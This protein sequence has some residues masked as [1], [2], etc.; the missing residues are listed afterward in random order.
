[1]AGSANRV[2]HVVQAIEVADQVVILA[3][4][5][6]GAGLDELRAFGHTAFGGALARHRDRRRVVV[7][8]VELR[9]GEGLGQ[10]HRRGT[11][12]AANVGNLGPGL[13]FIEHA[14]QGW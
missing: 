10:D 6:L 9:S 2:A 1:M 13:Q 11:M 7:E 8:T 5:I 14:G 3:G 4:E 12:P